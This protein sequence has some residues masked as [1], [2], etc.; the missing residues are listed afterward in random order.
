MKH[1]IGKLKSWALGSTISLMV[2]LSVPVSSATAAPLKIG[3]SDWPGWVAW[4]VA[5]DKGWFKEA[6][7][8]VDFE[9]FDYAASMDAFS[10]HKLDAVTMTNGDTL[11]TGANGG[12]S[13]MIIVTDYSAGNDMVIAK[14]QYKSIKD[15]KGKKIGVELGLVD[16]LLLLDALQ[17]AGLSDKDVTLVNAKTPETPQVLASPDIA[18]VAAWQPNAGSALQRVPGSHPVFTSADEPGLIYDAVAVDPASLSTRRADWEKIAKVW[19]RVVA[20][21]QDPKTQADAVKIMSARVGL[22]P[23]AYLPL[24]K[25]THLLGLTEAKSVMKKADGFR[26]LYGSSSIADAFNVKNDVYKTPQNIDS[27]IDPSIINGL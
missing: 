1:G 20:Y 26:S 18:A 24:L 22:T 11:S 2:A 10:A 27:Y 7:V 4:Q 17:K 15:L 21:I 12:K 13:K 9:W 8:D 16:H 23:E 6:G 3:Y 19:F 5:I 14:G 25:G